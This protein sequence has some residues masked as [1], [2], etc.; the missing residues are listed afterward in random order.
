MKK[1]EFSRANELLRSTSCLRNM[2]SFQDSAF[3]KAKG[4]LE[5]KAHSTTLDNME[6]LE[7]INTLSKENQILSNRC[8]VLQ[9]G[10]D[11]SPE[12]DEER[13]RVL[14]TT[15]APPD[16]PK[17]AGPTVPSTARPRISTVI[18]SEKKVQK[19]EVEARSAAGPTEEGDPDR[20]N[21]TISSPSM[22]SQWTYVTQQDS[23]T[24]RAVSSARS[25][26]FSRPKSATSTRGRALSTTTTSK[27]GSRLRTSIMR[28]VQNEAVLSPDA[29]PHEGP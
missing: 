24:P 17:T 13:G 25:K 18:D 16:R 7:R 28:R 4:V 20:E 26:S 1:E 19:G 8:K 9:K 11:L 21:E 2:L 29:A 10:R 27:V 15:S 5:R 3:S 23:K 14:L 22:T 6:L 12:R